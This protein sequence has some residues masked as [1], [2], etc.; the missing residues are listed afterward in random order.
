MRTD[1]AS[2]LAA[3]ALTYVRALCYEQHHPEL[4]VLTELKQ[5]IETELNRMAGLNPDRNK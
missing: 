2:D 5:M 1:M 4:L 3:N